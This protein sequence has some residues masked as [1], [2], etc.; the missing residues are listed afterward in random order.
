MTDLPGRLASLANSVTALLADKG[1]RPAV[2]GGDGFDLRGAWDGRALVLTYWCS[3][4]TGWEHL[5]GGH[6]FRMRRALEECADII[7]AAGH[8]VTCH[9]TVKTAQGVPIESAII[10]PGP[11]PE[12]EPVDP[13]LCQCDPAVPCERA[14]QLA[15]AVAE[16]ERTVDAAGAAFL[17]ALH[18]ASIEPVDHAPWGPEGAAALLDHTSGIL[19][20]LDPGPDTNVIS[21]MECHDC[22]S[23]A[24]H[25]ANAQA[26]TV[27]ER[28][29]HVAAVRAASLA[30]A[31]TIMDRAYMALTPGDR[32]HG[33]LR[34][35]AE[36][37][38]KVYLTAAAALGAP[39]DERH[40][41]YRRAARGRRGQRVNLRKGG[42]R[43]WFVRWGRAVWH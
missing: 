40:G 34:Q 16:L 18:E 33:T 14:E 29:A 24:C 43:Y 25:A 12:P 32:W 11:E 3:A 7:R 20:S 31:R 6:I 27:V 8:Q 42:T 37:L 28:A 22:T 39:V 4:D 26:R 23:P 21:G 30:A 5:T 17:D 9:P 41:R 15:I 36:D 13:S 10:F 19:T 2:R 38:F 1:H 35:T